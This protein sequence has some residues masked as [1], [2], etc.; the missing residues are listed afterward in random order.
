MDALVSKTQKLKINM[1]STNEEYLARQKVRVPSS[2]TGTS[3]PSMAGAA[4]AAKKPVGRPAKTAGGV[5]AKKPV[6]KSKSPPVMEDLTPNIPGTGAFQVEPPSSAGAAGLGLGMQAMTGQYQLETPVAAAAAPLPEKVPVEAY[7]QNVAPLAPVAVPAEM[8]AEK[9][10]HQH[11]P[12]PTWSS[13]GHIPFAAGLA[14]QPQT[15]APEQASM[16][17]AVGGVKQEDEVKRSIWDIP[18]TPAKS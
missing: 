6:T 2:S 12:T 9:Q 8:N 1:P 15:Q 3:R 10:Q 7:I 13:T 11:Q 16:S 4:V 5:V 14:A 17:L 18:D